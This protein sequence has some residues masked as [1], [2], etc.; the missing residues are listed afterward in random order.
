MTWPIIINRLKCNHKRGEV[1]AVP[2]HHAM[3][4]LAVNLHTQQ[5]MAV[6]RYQLYQSHI[7]AALPWWKKPPVLTGWVG[8]TAHLDMVVKTKAFPLLELKTWSTSQPPASM[9]KLYSSGSQKQV[10][11]Y[12]HSIIILTYL[13]ELDHCE[14]HYW[15]SCLCGWESQATTV[16]KVAWKI[17]TQSL[18]HNSFLHTKTSACSQHSSKSSSCKNEAGTGS[19][20]TSHTQCRYGEIQSQEAEQ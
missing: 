12:V 11:K 17:S 1:T 9:A 2:K 5:T 19:E 14:W 13:P 16:N 15:H 6:D 7:S 4:V 20:Q 8:P 18:S 3:K 10:S